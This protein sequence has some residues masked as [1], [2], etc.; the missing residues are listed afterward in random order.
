VHDPPAAAREA[1]ERLR[2]CDPEQPFLF[3]RSPRGTFTWWPFA[4][5]AATLASLL[6]RGPL[7]RATDGADDGRIPEELLELIAS[8]GAE[9]L[10]RANELLAVLSARSNA[11]AE[12]AA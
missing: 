12:N 6:D 11:C 3:F 8:T 7:E 9:D 10:A 1:L 2:R 5:A 4:R